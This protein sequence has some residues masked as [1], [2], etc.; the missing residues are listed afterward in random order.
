MI[1]M[2]RILALWLAAAGLWAS[3]TVSTPFRGVTHIYRTETAPRD[4]HI[5]IVKI[6]LDGSGDAVQ[7]DTSRGSRETVRQTTLDFLRKEHA[8]VAVNA[9][10]FTPFPSKEIEAWLVGYAASEGKDILGF[11]EARSSRTRSWLMRPRS[12]W[13]GNRAGGGPA[14]KSAGAEG[15]DGG[16]GLGADRHRRE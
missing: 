10:F 1:R 11:R 3:D 14:A 2:L 7:A 4:L 6:D 15:V 9:H 5:H 16:I 12:P 13:T 8:K